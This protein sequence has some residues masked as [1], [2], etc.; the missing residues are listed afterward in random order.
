MSECIQLS[1]STTQS[2]HGAKEVKEFETKA[3]K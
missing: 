3:E 2:K 1:F